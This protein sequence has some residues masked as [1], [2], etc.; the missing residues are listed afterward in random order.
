MVNA[1]DRWGG[2]PLR[3][4]VREGRPE[5]ADFL[6]S[7]EGQLGYDEVMAS[8]ELCELAKKGQL[9]HLKAARVPSVKIS[10]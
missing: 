10:C 9:E 1:Q 8:S 2:T 5:V 4:A 3:D 6:C 7:R